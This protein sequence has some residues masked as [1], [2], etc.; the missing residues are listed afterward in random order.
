LWTAKNVNLQYDLK[1]K[2]YKSYVDYFKRDVNRELEGFR[3]LLK[4]AAEQVN[5]KAGSIIRTNK[6]ISQIELNDV[7]SEEDVSVL[8]NQSVQGIHPP[9]IFRNL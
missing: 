9:S 6:S 8:I 3:M 5:K 7:V 1:L 4:L 2:Q